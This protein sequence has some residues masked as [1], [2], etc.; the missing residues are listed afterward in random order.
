MLSILEEQHESQ[1]GWSSEGRVIGDKVRALAG[2]WMVPDFLGHHKDLD[3]YSQQGG[4]PMG[5][6]EHRWNKMSLQFSKISQAL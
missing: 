6:S 1:Y 3:F 5:N 2:S 4:K